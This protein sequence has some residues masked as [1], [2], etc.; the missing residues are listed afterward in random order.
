M[1]EGP[2]HRGGSF[3]ERA[4][5]ETRL[6]K[7]LRDNLRRRKQQARAQERPAPAR[8]PGRGGPERD[9]PA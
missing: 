8:P 5:R 6:A 1:S 3:A 7:A 9:P 4:A 2:Q